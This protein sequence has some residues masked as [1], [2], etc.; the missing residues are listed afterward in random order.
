M[1]A[2]KDILLGEPLETHSK[3]PDIVLVVFSDF[4]C[5]FCVRYFQDVIGPLLKD[6]TQKL[7]LVHKHFPLPFHQN[8][9]GWAIESECI[10]KNI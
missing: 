3:N 4:E 2:I 10:R 6:T 8:A 9:Y 7:A 5:P 1:E